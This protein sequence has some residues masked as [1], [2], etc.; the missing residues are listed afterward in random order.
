[1]KA[2]IGSN[3]ASRWID[4]INAIT[5]GITD[6]DQSILFHYQTSQKG[7]CIGNGSNNIA[8]AG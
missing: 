7:T 3:Y 1:M 6:G 4:K 5:A 8:D 2:G